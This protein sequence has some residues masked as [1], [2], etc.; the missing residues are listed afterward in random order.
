MEL[1]IIDLIEKN[2][3]TKLTTTNNIRLLDRIKECFTDMQQQIFLTS[4]YCHINYDPELDFV[5]NFDT[6]WKWLEFSNKINAKRLLEKSFTIDV[7]YKISL[8]PNEEQ[9]KKKHGGNNR[10]N[11][12]LN[13]K[14]FKKFCIKAG[15]KKAD[16]THDYFL[17]LERLL[18]DVMNEE[19]QE[20]REQFKNHV[21]ETNKEMM[22][23]LAN[24]QF[25]K[26]LLREKTILQQFPENKQCVY[27]ATIDNK[28]NKGETLVKF[29]CSNFLQRR[30]THHKNIFDNFILINAFEVQNKIHVEK[31]I[32]SHLKLKNCRSNLLL[33]SKN[34]TEMF[35]ID[36]KLTLDIIDKTIKTIVKSF[37]N[38]PENFSRLFNENLLLLDENQ[39]LLEEINLL[40]DKIKKP[41]RNNEI[42]CIIENVEYQS[43]YGSR[44]EVWSRFAYKTNGNL[45]K[46]D[47]VLGKNEKIISKRC[48]EQC[49]QNLT[50]LRMKIIASLDKD[51]EEEQL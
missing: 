19:C 47:L 24:S 23:C 41:K 6:V 36:D 32:K 9:D 14:T 11:I 7:D 15:T 43:L 42:N 25:E 26:D 27:F 40:K 4:F 16:E 10:E 17:K 1:N 50:K 35:V 20:I 13:L 45:T 51:K 18:L 3:L 2:P 34:H 28:N 38:T 48:Q 22:T 49:K 21:I 12:M 8:F 46:D 37:E 39:R 31:A 33:D 29:G 44:E 5:I 30:V